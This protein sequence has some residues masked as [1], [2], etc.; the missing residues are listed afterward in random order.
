MKKGIG[1]HE[2]ERQ[3]FLSEGQDG[4]EERKK[5]LLNKP[6]PDLPFC[7]VTVSSLKIKVDPSSQTNQKYINK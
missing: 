6:Q 4:E 2:M 1:V 7:L 3:I 5:P